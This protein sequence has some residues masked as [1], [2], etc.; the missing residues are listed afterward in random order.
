MKEII[1]L[2]CG[3]MLAASGFAESG[4]LTLDEALALARQNSPELRA[5]RINT[6]AAQKAT[7]AAGL[8]TNPQLAFETEGM[9][10][11]LD[12]FNETEY[13]LGIQQTFQRG[14]KRK[15]EREGGVQGGWNRLQGRSRKGTGPVGR[16]SKG[17][18]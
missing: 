18:Y 13:T 17:L 3:T 5:A 10:G 15:S 12:G 1:A 6:Q 8:W 7:A 16:S 14:G 11:D 2:L 4:K 9:G